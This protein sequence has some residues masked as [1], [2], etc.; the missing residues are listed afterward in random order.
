MY[1]IISFIGIFIIFIYTYINYKSNFT[2]LRVIGHQQ[3]NT[4]NDIMNK[5]RNVVYMKLSL[6]EDK[7][8]KNYWV[9]HRID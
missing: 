3:L 4:D 2:T 1:T 8:K 5:D 6:K 9:I 7:A